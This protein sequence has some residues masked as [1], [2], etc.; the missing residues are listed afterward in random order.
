MERR[1]QRP[2]PYRISTIT[3]NGDIGCPVSLKAFYKHLPVAQANGWIFVELGL[4]EFRG[5]DPN[6]KRRNNPDRKNFVN[7]VTVI[8]DFGGN[9]R[10]NIKLFKNGN[11]HMTGIRSLEDGAKVVRMLAD[12]IKHIAEMQ[13]RRAQERRAQEQEQEQ[14]EQEQEQAEQA[15][16]EQ[17][18]QEP[19]Q[20]PEPVEPY[21]VEDVA[22]V[23]ADNFK[24]RMINCDFTTPFRIRRKDLHNM[25]IAPPFNNISSFQPGTYPGVK[26]HYFWNALA[27]GGPA[28]HGRCECMQHGA[29]NMCIGKGGGQGLGD[30]KKVTIAVFESGK[31]LVTGATSIEQVDAAY[32]WICNVL[33]QHADRLQKVV[34][35]LPV[36][37][38]ATPAERGA[39][40]VA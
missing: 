7:Q 3:C 26:I 22:K 37:E 15:E 36:A 28:S 40:V 16:Q 2:T 13:E 5:L 27:P 12:E 23:T 18:E 21:I 30:C 31:V 29:E 32:T 39:S 17:A 6:V 10:P 19:E 4:G 11:V 1:L 35:T 38:R 33:M 8:R 9:Y 14:V 24:C 34:Y 20:E 25:L